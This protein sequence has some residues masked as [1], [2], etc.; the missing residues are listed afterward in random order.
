M[1]C[2][3]CQAEIKS[4]YIDGRTKFGPWANMCPS[5]FFTGPGVGILGVGN[6]TKFVK[7]KGDWIKA[8]PAKKTIHGVVS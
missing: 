1:I 2:D 4:V 3:M 6:G 8:P 5:C 7:H